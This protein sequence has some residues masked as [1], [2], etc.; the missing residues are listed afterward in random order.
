MIGRI[1]ILCVVFLAG[2]V[3][4]VDNSP[5]TTPTVDPVV[6]VNACGVAGPPQ[7]VVVTELMFVGAT[8][9][10][11]VGLDL[12]GRVSDRQDASSCRQADFVDA[13]GN[14]GID[15]QFARLLPALESVAGG[16]SVQAV[17]QRTINSGNVLLMFDLQRVDDPV[18]DACVEVTVG[19]GIGQPVIGGDGFI[20]PSQTF[21]HSDD[22]DTFVPDATLSAGV[23]DAGPFDLSLPVVVDT[24]DVLVDIRDARLRATIA[25]DGSMTGLIAG[26]ISVP[27]FVASIETIDASGD[28]LS[29]VSTA[30]NNLADMGKDGDGVCR[31]LSI[32]LAFRATP[33]FFFEDPAP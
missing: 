10:V 11:T 29:L 15:N 3:D 2:C 18:D 7:T 4:Y 31:G 20:E 23:L 32:S 25:E 16:D 5:A 13:D 9:N 21:D 24:F 27:E 17:V 22:P 6:D 8:G 33:A 14:T 1:F 28:V 19:R 30:L 26:A 12:D